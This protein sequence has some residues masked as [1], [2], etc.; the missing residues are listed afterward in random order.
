[1]TCSAR[2]RGRS[3]EIAVNDRVVT[4]V[5]LDGREPDRFGDVVYPIPNEI[6]DRANGVLRVT[7]VAKRARAPQRSTISVYFG[8]RRKNRWIA[9][10]SSPLC[11]IPPPCSV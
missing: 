7:F 6:V 9:A 11:R 10:F 4:A 3:V 8:L 5:A 2:Q 1:V